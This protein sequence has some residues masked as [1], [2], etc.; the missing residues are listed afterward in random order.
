MLF[1]SQRET[2]LAVKTSSTW[3]ITQTCIL[4]KLC[5]NLLSKIKTTQQLTPF[6]VVRLNWHVLLISQ[7]IRVIQRVAKAIWWRHIK[8]MREIGIPI[9]AMFF[10]CPRVSTTSRPQSVSCS[11]LITN[12]LHIQQVSER[13]LHLLHLNKD[14]LL[15]YLLSTV[16]KSYRVGWMLVQL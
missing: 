4:V 6:L 7:T 10:S 8:Y 16:N 2:K 1:A 5:N 11:F 14:Y 3:N 12:S 9:Y 13:K 15:T